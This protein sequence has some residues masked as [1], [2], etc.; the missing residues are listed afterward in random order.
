MFLSLYPGMLEDLRAGVAAGDGTR[1]RRTAHGLKGAT[2]TL[3]APTATALLQKLEEHGETN[4]LSEAAET[5]PR[6]DAA[7]AD[8]QVALVGL[9]LDTK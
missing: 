3:R 7:L 4:R 6:L 1:V 2:A 5:M 9:E 8:L